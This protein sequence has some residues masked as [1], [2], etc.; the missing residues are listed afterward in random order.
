MKVVLLEDVK[1]TGKKD[2]IIEVSDGFARNFLL[3]KKKAKEATT[4]TLNAIEKAKQAAAFREAQKKQEAEV[5]SKTLK[6]K[7]VNVTARGGEAGKLY[8]TVTNQ[9]IADA[10]KAQLNVDLDKRKI[11]LDEPIRTAGQHFAT[12]R[13]NAGISTRV[14]VNV[15]VTAK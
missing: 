6:G 2:Q 15:T 5:L 13:L 10:L 11:E 1:G 8:G 4:E 7:V 3:P 14:I 9:E 12:L